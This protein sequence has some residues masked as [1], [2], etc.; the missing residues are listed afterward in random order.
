M[1]DGGIRLSQCLTQQGE[2]MLLIWYSLPEIVQMLKEFR[3]CD[4][5]GMIAGIK[6]LNK[7]LITPY[8]NL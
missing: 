6:F 8:L 7:S 2:S 1:T 3:I 4:D 5:Y